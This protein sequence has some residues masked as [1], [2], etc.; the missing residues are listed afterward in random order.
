MNLRALL[1]TA[2]LITVLGGFTPAGAADDEG[3]ID[4]VLCRQDGLLCARLDLSGLVSSKLVEEMEDGVEFALACRVSLLRPRRIW[5][6]VTVARSVR[7]LRIGYGVVT[8]D[9]RATFAD[10]LSGREIR[11]PSLAG[12][13]QFL[14]D[15]VTAE[16]IA[17]DSLETENRYFVRIQISR[18][19]LTAL[20][21]ASRQTPAES[22]S[23]V[24][25]LFD[26]FLQFTGFGREEYS[27]E[28]RLFSLGEI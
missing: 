13:H 5:G 26:K 27:V 7:L 23:P 10:S 1:V 19:S 24:R 20:N 8:E 18:L 12:L 25:F 2:I 22:S 9:F 15:S 17:I 16:I 21:L 14:A 3:Q 11:F 28:S 6:S 4:Y